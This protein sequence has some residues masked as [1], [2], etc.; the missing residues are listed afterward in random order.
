MALCMHL[1]II[2]KQI[3][4]DDCAPLHKAVAH[5]FTVVFGGQQVSARTEKRRDHTKAGQKALSVSGRLE[6]THSIFAFSCWLM[7][8]FC[9]VL[10][11]MRNRWYNL[12]F[13]GCIAAKLVGR[14]FAECT[15]NPS[16]VCERIFWQLLY[17]GVAAQED[18]ALRPPGRR[19]AT[20]TA[21]CH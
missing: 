3:L 21:V 12:G 16:R 13:C 15:A 7:R 4:I 14:C 5:D 19:H 18:R 11:V 10:L 9:A 2:E 6:A 1:Q 8:I 17:C 20:S